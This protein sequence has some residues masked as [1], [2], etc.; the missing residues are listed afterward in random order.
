MVGDPTAE[1]KM[2]A[3]P[4]TSPTTRNGEIGP[5][6]IVVIAYPPGAAMS[7]EA[8]PILLDLVDRGVIRVLD[9]LFVTKAA[10]GSVA[11]FEA[12]N[13][14]GTD[15]GEFK[16]FEGASSGLLGDDDVQTAAEALD[17]G[18]S[19]LLLVV[20]NRWAA[21]F[22]A[23][24]RRNGGVLVD[25]QRISVNDVIEVLDALEASDQP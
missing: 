14:D 4:A 21:P 15:A 22:V 16:V 18:T 23:A 6:D 19:A 5:I 25:I 9:A 17:P 20:E 12:K 8:A 7:G 10:D 1:A 11:G 13:L 3:S 2:T 24:V